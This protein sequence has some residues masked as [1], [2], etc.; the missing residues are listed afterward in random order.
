METYQ[1]WYQKLMP[2]FELE[3]AIVSEKLAAGINGVEW[4][5]LQTLPTKEKKTSMEQW[6]GFL[7]MYKHFDINAVMK[8]VLTMNHDD[9]YSKY[10][11]NWWISLDETLTCLSLMRSAD[12]NS[13]SDFIQSINKKSPS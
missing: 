4:L 13:Y 8:D 6:C 7:N 2:A 5:V 9:F 12:Y 1:D 3:Q 10:R 11:F